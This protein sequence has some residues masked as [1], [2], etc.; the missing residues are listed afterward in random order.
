MFGF[1]PIVDFY[2][3]LAFFK[4]KQIH[5]SLFFTVALKIM[6]FL[7]YVD[8]I[9]LIGNQPFLISSFVTTLGKEFELTNLGPL[10]YFLGLEATITSTGLRLSQTKY[11]ID[12]LHRHSMTDYKPYTTPV[13]YTSQLSHLHGDLEPDGTEYRQNNYGCPS[14]L[15]L[16]SP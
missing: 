15:D 9:I 6:I 12:L 3:S 1:D 8:D 13:C 16:H 14:V 10:S 4:V 7:L 11:T 5:I 2:Y